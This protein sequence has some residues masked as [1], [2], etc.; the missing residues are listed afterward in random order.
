MPRQP[1]QHRSPRWGAALRGEAPPVQ[2]KS[3]EEPVRDED[4]APP[5]ETADGAQPV[6][7]PEDNRFMSDR[8]RN[9]AAR[10]EREEWR[11][12]GD[13]ED[14]DFRARGKPWD[15]DNTGDAPAARFGEERRFYAGLPGERERGG[16]DK[17][18]D[19]RAPGRGDGA[20]RGLRDRWGR[21]S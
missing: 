12:R 14:T 11:G 1:E 21:K 20:S 8:D 4:M 10:W 18:D 3:G 6:A 9:G 13:F 2:A 17:P 15:W 7:D 16:V 19:D 5:A